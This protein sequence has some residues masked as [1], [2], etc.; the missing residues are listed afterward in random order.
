VLILLAAVSAGLVIFGL[1]GVRSKPGLT[2]DELKKQGAGSVV[3]VA[4]V[5][6]FAN[7]ETGDLIFQDHTAGMH[8]RMAS[9]PG[10]PHVGDRIALR[11]QVTNEYKAQIGHDSVRLTHIVSEVLGQAALPQPQPMNIPDLFHSTDLLNAKRVEISGIVRAATRSGDRVDLE[12]GDGGDVIPV[13]VLGADR[14]NVEALIDGRL[15]VRGALNFAL[16]HRRE[17]LEPRLWVASPADLEMVSRPRAEIATV[18]SIR[19]LITDPQWVTRGNRVRVSGTVVRSDADGKMLIEN[20]GIVMPVEAAQAKDFAAGD[21]IEA[22]GWPARYRFTTLLR[23]AQVAHIKRLPPEVVNSKD[24]SLRVIESVAQ[25]RDIGNEGA[26]KLYPV[27]LTAVITA[28][29]PLWDCYFIQMDGHGIF[30]DASGQS[31]SQLQAGMRVHLNG[32]TAAGDFA[33]VIMHPKLTVLSKEAL[34]QPQRIDPQVAPSGVYDSKWVEL[35]GLMRPIESTDNG[36]TFKLITAVGTVPVILINAGERS[37][38]DQLV[39]AQV[40]A[41]GVF[42]T[43]FTKEGVLIGYR[44]FI[45]SP[46]FMTVVRPAPANAANPELRPIADL[47]RFSPNSQG[48]LRVR[49]RGVVTLRAGDQ[50]YL[51][52]QSG[53]TR[54][55]AMGVEA[56]PGDVVE[57]TGYPSPSEQGPFLSD[58]V[59][60]EVGQKVPERPLTATPEQVLQSGMDNRLVQIEARLLSHVPGNMQQTL[61]LQADQTSFNAQLDEGV[62]LPEL[63]EG[64]VVRV[65]GIA[66]VQRERLFYRQSDFVP[67]SFRILLRSANDVQVIRQ[68][69]WW[70]LRHAWPV[71]AVLTLSIVLA[72]LWVMV[73]R[74][75]VH[76]QTAEIYR[77]RSFLRQVVDL[78]PNFIFVKDPAGH[79]TLVNRALAE[80]YKKSP[81]EIVGRTDRELGIE[82]QRVLMREQDNRDVLSRKADTIAREEKYARGDQEIW[83]HTV[84]RALLGADGEPTHVLGVSNDITMHKQAEQTLLKA[85]EAAE[86][87]NRAKSE[88]LANMSHEIRTPLNGII[89]MSELCLDTD[90]SREQRE[91]VETVK[92]SADGLLNIINDILD[93]SKIEAG[94]LD[95][96]ETEFDVRETLDSALKTVSFR[97]FEKGLELFC[98]VAFDVPDFA[99]GDANR[100]RQI[101]L[102][103][104]GNAIK[105]TERGEVAVSAKLVSRDS[106]RCTVQFTVADTGI[107]IAPDRQALIFSPFVQAD[108]STTRRY[109]GTGL[110]LTISKRLV[111][112]MHGQMWLES[113]PGKGSQFHFTVSFKIAGQ[114]QQQSISREV[115]ELRDV[116]ALI[117]DDND[118]NRRILREAVTR[119]GMRAVVATDGREALRELDEAARAGDPCTLVLTD[120][121]MPEMDGLAL[122]EQIR[123]RDHAATTVIMMLTSS[124]QREDSARCRALGVESYLVK[125]VRLVELRDTLLQAR[126]I[127]VQAK[128]SDS[129]LRATPAAS[130]AGLNILVAEDN[131]VNQ[132]LM[133][134]LL[135]KRGHRVTIADSGKTALQALEQ[136]QFDI[137]LM[138]VQM[139]ELDGFQATAE[140]RRRESGTTRRIPIIA[141][142]AHAMSGDRERCLTAGMDGYLTKPINPKEL[143][144]TLRQYGGTAAIDDNRA[145]KEA[146]SA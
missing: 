57:V 44:I 122:V 24:A 49:V 82:E 25:I 23:R 38:L 27:S 131:P 6:T 63:R 98:D 128:Q 138:D 107:G 90:M 54:V 56:R 31:V 20:G 26:K 118:T 109:G 72:M 13:T 17:R 124:G 14:T 78:C 40:R 84:K 81:V 50:L 1:A 64:S 134:R 96:E 19:A 121:N 58:A 113:E 71:L 28:V 9:G 16:D 59:V 41:L 39:D 139:P 52:D 135:N 18:P 125:P 83:L 91:Y 61:V 32:L 3:R 130:S 106:E 4:G 80:I 74:R 141:L 127:P 53:S 123:Q 36:L 101:V 70:N 126:G 68:T 12:L 93:F 102:N 51:E 66:L 8:V 79:F 62:Q 100:L 67:V 47:L 2:I 34:P 29:Q 104:V 45:N 85:R 33:P 15:K 97:A 30:V 112:M 76:A 145:M 94:K 129:S 46:D 7:R 73:L 103:L 21:Q 111:S 108:A 99:K 10:L 146:A 133:T 132:M 92:L 142:T 42:A 37:R 143:D 22:T 137:V 114:A 5:V 77:Q 60:R 119:W 120:R 75:R 117:V 140:I 11:A 144:T 43:T 65:M 95:L 35:E 55:Q 86:A 88:F 110:G 105:F 48:N 115:L 87:A 136:S 89:G 116:K 69:P